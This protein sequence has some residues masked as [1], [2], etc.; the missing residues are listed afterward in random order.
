[1][2]EEDIIGVIMVCL[3]P[4]DYIRPKN[5][6]HIFFFSVH[7]DRLKH[8][9]ADNFSSPQRGL[10]PAMVLYFQVI[11]AGRRLLEADA[12]ETNFPSFSACLSSLASCASFESVLALIRSVWERSKLVCRGGEL[13]IP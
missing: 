5:R 8:S 4:G 11:G 9:S 13:Y 3:A 7:H 6:E 1:M 12:R 2:E 10:A